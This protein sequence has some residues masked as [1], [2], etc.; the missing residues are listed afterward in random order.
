MVSARL[1]VRLGTGGK[2]IGP[3]LKNGKGT[4][5]FVGGDNEEEALA[6]GADIEIDHAHTIDAN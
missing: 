5:V 2:E 4:I 3:V 6:V 1:R